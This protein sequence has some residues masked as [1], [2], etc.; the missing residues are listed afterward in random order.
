MLHTRQINV[1]VFNLIRLKAFFVFIYKALY[2]YQLIVL[3]RQ[4]EVVFMIMLANINFFIK[5]QQNPKLFPKY[6]YARNK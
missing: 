1:L 6:T 3:V 4:F 2:M 5:L